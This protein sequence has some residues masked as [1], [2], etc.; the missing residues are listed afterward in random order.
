MKNFKSALKPFPVSLALGVLGGAALIVTTIVTTKGL[1]I[2]IPYT[3]LIIATFA[4]LRAVQWSAFS[5]RFTTSFLTFMV[6]TIILYLFIGIYDAGTIL[7]IPIWGHIWRLGLMA[8]I[9]GALSFSVAYFANIGRSQ[10]V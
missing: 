10:I 6:A 4:A 9:G 7:D 5:K 2:F 3:A 8:A 1:A